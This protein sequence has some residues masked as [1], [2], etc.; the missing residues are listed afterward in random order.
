MG[1]FFQDIKVAIRMMIKRPGFSIVVVLTLALGIGANTAIFS[2][3]NAVLLRPLAYKDS[4]T[5][6]NIWGKI[7][8]QGI[9]RLGF[10][11]PEYWDL[12]DRNQSLA[13]LGAYSLGGGANLTSRDSQPMQVSTPAVSATLFQ[14]LG[15]Q[16]A[17]GRTFTLDEDQP[18]H[19]REAL[20]SF[21]LW[22]SL[23]GGDP[24]IVGRSIELDGQAY[25]IVGVLRQDFSL[26]GKHDLWIPLGLDRAKP[27]NRGSHYL[28]VTAR[29]K[30]GVN[31]AQVSAEMDR[32]AA[33]LA[34]EYPNN[35][36]AGSG[37]G[38][39]V[40]PLK[41]Q[42]V[43]TIRPA[44][45]VLLGA[46]AFVL[47]IACV[48]VANLLL[49]QASAREKELSIRAAMGAGRA[50]IVRQFVTES[51][52]LAV[53]GGAVGLVIA[54]W[55]VY[56]LRTLAPD[57]IPRMDEV[58]V[59]PLVLGFTLGISLLTGLVFGLAPAWQVSRT[60]LQSSLK[61]TGQSTSAAS[62]TRRLRGILV[63]SEMALAV[64][65]LVGAGL[66]IRSFQHLLEVSP[67]FQRQHLLSMRLSPPAKAYPDGTPLQAFY[68]QVLNRVKTIPGVQAA[69]A[70]SELPMSDSYSSGSTFVEQTSAVDLPRYAP[71]SNLPFIEADFR[72]AAP[73]YFEAMQIP[74][75]RGRFL[76]DADTADASFV[77]VVDQDFARRFWPNEDP[78]GKRIAI[79]TIPKSNP[80]MP[81]WCAVVGVVGHVK[82]YG[83][84]SGG[85]EQAY[86]PV[87]QSPFFRSMYLAVRTTLEPAS[88]TSA[89][90]QQ[91][92]AIDKD[93]PV[94]EV[95]TMDQ[96]LSNSVVQPRLNL[97]LLVTFAAL[98]LVLAAVGIYGVMAYT[99]T[100][101][102]HEIGIRMAIGAQT[103]DVLKQVLMEG[104]RLAVMGLVLG[105]AGSLA[106]NRL[107]AT[108]L[109]GVKPTDPLTFAAVAVLLTSVMLAACYIPARRATRVD[110]MVALRYE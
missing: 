40:V 9:P 45:L 18:G 82:H 50:R 57:N 61:E 42:I 14:I 74:L 5:L 25:A 17:L 90:R 11:E 67:G 65:L 46:V 87:T 107:M 30:P 49:A 3:V 32:F 2:V 7:D 88:V 73:G 43:A 56:A 101:R 33:Q 93:M 37:W 91:V 92:L 84:D 39:F 41:E 100:Q 66:L 94:Y 63:V 58:R 83:P 16:T 105:L 8:N 51:M 48:N 59:D 10:S 54:Y 98:A 44:L 52:V 12:R 20:L 103:E 23:F 89:I 96:L 22:K 19:D 47:L 35:Y 77:A 29:L 4:A 79:N 68:Q 95:S 15:V 109:F 21:A 64:L 86:F 69:G 34:R 55:G 62:A 81:Q 85:R 102:T 76:T 71:L 78:I 104:A 26:G 60:N 99:V 28:R 80:L 97:A 70:V 13:D 72:T 75:V 110:P 1:T 106:A 38:M 6:V 27:Q 108:L 31:L 24:Q 36:L 53:M